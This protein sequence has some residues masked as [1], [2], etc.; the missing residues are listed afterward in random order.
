MELIFG[1]GANQLAAVACSDG[2]M[3]QQLNVSSTPL[4]ILP[5]G[6]TRLIESGR[7]SGS[8]PSP[9]RPRLGSTLDNDQGGRSSV[10]DE[11]LEEK[12]LDK[13]EEDMPNDPGG[14][15]ALPDHNNKCTGG[16]KGSNEEQQGNLSSQ[17]TAT[18]LIVDRT[19]ADLRGIF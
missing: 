7:S 3:S 4:R 10:C 18:N 14:G 2:N 8:S 17:V 16:G 13:D 1:P 12:G 11:E 6:R 5:R 15:T 19:D 9:V